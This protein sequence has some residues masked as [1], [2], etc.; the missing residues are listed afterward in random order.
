MGFI[1]VDLLAS[2]FD[3]FVHTN[4]HH[5]GVLALLCCPQHSP[6]HSEGLTPPH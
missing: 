3:L 4:C 2:C 1:G 5:H 6:M